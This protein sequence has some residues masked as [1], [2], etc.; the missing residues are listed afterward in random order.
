MKL[1]K[2]IEKELI[3]DLILFCLGLTEISLFYMNNFLLIILLLIT[4]LIGIKLWYED[5]DIYFLLTGAVIGTV[6]EIVCIHFGVWT[7]TNPTFLG[8]PVWLPLAW[9]LTTILIK[10]IAQIFVKIEKK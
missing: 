2:K 5:Y 4:W 8:V 6:G 7:Y 9:G 3:L 10:R 1:T